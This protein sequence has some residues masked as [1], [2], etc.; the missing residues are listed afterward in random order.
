MGDR[1]SECVKRML[2]RFES[3]TVV[4][5]AELVIDAEGD[6]ECYAIDVAE[7]VETIA[8]LEA[9]AERKT[10]LVSTLRTLRGDDSERVAELERKLQSELHTR[11]SLQRDVKAL[12]EAH[13]LRNPM[14]RGILTESEIL[15][16]TLDTLR[17]LATQIEETSV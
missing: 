1:I 14:P 17:M 4:Q 3:L 9:D 16:A 13:T 7:M 10:Q 5:I 11:R 12:R 15:D 2:A 8:T 6:S